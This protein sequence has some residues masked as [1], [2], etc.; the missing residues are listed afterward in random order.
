MAST[1]LDFNVLELVSLSV[2][3]NHLL[4]SFYNSEFKISHKKDHSPVTDADLAVSELIIAE[5]T[6]ITPGI[7]VVS[8]ENDLNQN[9]DII[10]NEKIFWLIDPLDGTSSFISKKGTFSVNI[11][12]IINGLAVWGLISSPLDGTVYYIAQDGM[13]VHK[14]DGESSIIIKPKKVDLK[15][16]DFLVSHQNLNQNTQDFITKFNINTITPIPSGIKFALL[17]EGK[18]DIYPRFKDTCTW[19]TAA[20]HAILN[21]VGGDIVDL[22]GKSLR[23]NLPTISNPYFI[24][25]SDICLIDIFINKL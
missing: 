7:K 25:V 12:L 22:N 17:A 16:I 5:L 19:D 6:K 9:L 4:I 8:E 2:K 1:K 13:S 21:A 20:G 10:K 23:Y 3:A 18:G 24:A 14:Y 15:S 11:A